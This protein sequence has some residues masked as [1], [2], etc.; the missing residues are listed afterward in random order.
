MLKDEHWIIATCAIVVGLVL[1]IPWPK[2]F[3]V[4]PL[5]TQPPR[6]QVQVAAE[7][8]RESVLVDVEGVGNGSGVV[9]LRDGQCY[10]LTAGHVA[11]MARTKY[12]F[13]HV[14]TSQS[15]YS[16]ADNT[17]LSVIG[18]G[19]VVATGDDE[20]GLDLALI[21]LNTPIFHYSAV[22]SPDKD[23][24]AG[25][26]VYGVGSN[27]GEVAEGSFYTGVVSAV[28][29]GPS[30]HTRDL[31]NIMA[32]CGYSGGGIF[33]EKGEL[34]GILTETIR[35]TSITGMVPVRKIREWAKRHQV[36]RILFGG[37]LPQ[38]KPVLK[39]PLN[40]INPDPVYWL[41]DTDWNDL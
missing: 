6:T 5:D 12:G 36:E 8:Q 30:W 18:Y 10:V 25:T 21:Q 32:T 38:E 28:G 41:K 23:A 7:L 34:L 16:N 31:V 29:K 3:P 33:S 22:V 4:G 39:V 15:L 9:F 14:S 24:P 2:F 35:G 27:L 37:R 19:T 11:D 17:H 1:V 40:G 20:L 13:V 26:V